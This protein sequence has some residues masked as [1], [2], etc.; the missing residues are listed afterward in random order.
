GLALLVASGETLGQR[1]PG[2]GGPAATGPAPARDNDATPPP[3]A[4]RAAPR[5]SRAALSPPGT[6]WY[7]RPQSGPEQP[8]SGPTDPAVYSLAG[9][10]ERLRGAAGPPGRARA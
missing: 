9:L 2:S 5:Q 7:A 3:P 1:G 4:P 10:P 8:A 6:E